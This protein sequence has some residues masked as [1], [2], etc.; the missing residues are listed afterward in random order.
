MQRLPIYILA[1][2]ASNLPG[3]E[4]AR[5]PYRGEPL[6]LNQA[7]TW[8]VRAT[9]LTVVAEQTNQYDDLHLRTIGDVA[10]QHG[11]LGGLYTALLDAAAD[12]DAGLPAAIPELDETG[13]PEA[14]P[15]DDWI[16]LVASNRVGVDPAWIDLLLAQRTDHT[17]AVLFRG[18]R[19]TQPYESY[20]ALYHIGLLPKITDFISR[21]VLAPWRLIETVPH[22]TLTAPPGWIRVQKLTPPP[23]ATVASAAR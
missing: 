7:R 16:L 17:R 5:M 2:G 20:C 1:G 13:D 12:V 10:P 9:R 22:T 8:A 11:P 15:L 6:V 14:P 21:S 3:R 19:H 4:L 18:A 23:V